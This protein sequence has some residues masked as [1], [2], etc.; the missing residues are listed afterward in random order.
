MFSLH[1]ENHTQ[2][3]GEFYYFFLSLIPT[4]ENFDNR[5]IFEFLIFHISCL[6]NFRHQNK[7]P[8]KICKKDETQ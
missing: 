4:N 8:L 1:T 7:Y 2:K 6:A 3:S 5:L